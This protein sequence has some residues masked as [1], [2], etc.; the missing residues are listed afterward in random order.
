MDDTKFFAVAG[1]PILHSRSP[2]MFRAAFEAGSLNAVYLRFAASGANEIA[3]MARSMHIHGFNITSPYKEKILPFLNEMDEAARRSG[4]VNTVIFDKDKLVGFNTDIEGVRG[5]LLGHGVAVRGKKA[6]VLGAGGAAKAAALALILQGA[7]VTLINRTPERARDIARTFSCRTAPAKDMSQEMDDT[8]ILVSCISEGGPMVPRHCLRKDLVVLDAHYREE[9]PLV[10][11]ARAGKCTVIDGREWLLFQGASAFRHFTGLT[12]P[13]RAMRSALYD[14]NGCARRNVALIGFMGTGKSTVSR[15]L[16]KNLK[17][18]HIDIDDEIERKNASSITDIFK[19]LGQGPFRRMEERQI[20]LA[21]GMA[22][23]VISCGGGAVLNAASVDRLRSSSIVIW[24]SANVETVF[25]RV[26]SDRSRPLLN[27]PDRRP[28]IEKM[29]RLRTG[30][31]ARACDLIINTDGKEPEEIA[32][33]IYD[34][35]NTSL[36]R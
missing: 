24:L 32:E 16:A 21:A 26:G 29:L 35:I 15:H 34:E 25:Q 28:E 20:D 22:G 17:M 27:V 11:D 10:R 2:E 8:D 1:N 5:A 36:E 4:A 12:P 31:Y 23:A 3:R 14:D 19:D 33:R 18:T 13:V 6:L 30:Y 9:T 7:G